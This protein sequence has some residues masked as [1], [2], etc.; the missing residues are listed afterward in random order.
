MP[1]KFPDL[2]TMS[3]DHRS[4]NGI[5]LGFNCCDREMQGGVYVSTVPT[6]WLAAIGKLEKEIQLAKPP[7][8]CYLV[9]VLLCLLRCFHFLFLQV[10]SN[11]H[12]ARDRLQ[13]FLSRYRNMVSSHLSLWFYAWVYQPIT[14]AFGTTRNVGK[15]RATSCP[16]PFRCGGWG[17]PRAVLCPRRFDCGIGNVYFWAS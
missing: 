11:I 10:D 8:L 4:L 14:V 13:F 6:P 2:I 15:I 5:V 3:L 9:Q 16:N 1:K 17:T 12:G 7:R